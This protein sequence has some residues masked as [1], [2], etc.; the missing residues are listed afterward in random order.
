MAWARVAFGKDGTW[1]AYVK[2]TDMATM[3][4]FVTD[5]G[6]KGRKR[7]SGFECLMQTSGWQ[8]VLWDRKQWRRM[9]FK[10][11]YL[12]S[13]FGHVEL[14]KPMELEVEIFV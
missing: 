11:S 13:Q 2:Y 10:E 9:R 12:K 8:V 1:E 6:E 14:N 4:D 3:K 5:G 7:N